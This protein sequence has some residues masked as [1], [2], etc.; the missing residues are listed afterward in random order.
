[1]EL[2]DRLLRDLPRELLRE[3]FLLLERDRLE[4]EL[5]VEPFLL[6]E[7]DR[8]GLELELEADFDGEDELF[9]LLR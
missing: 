1:M 6:L 5:E 9:R 2:R 3:L 4:P 7:R 8:L